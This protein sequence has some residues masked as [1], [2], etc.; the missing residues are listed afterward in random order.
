V[1]GNLWRARNAVMVLVSVVVAD[2]PAAWAQSQPAAPQ[3]PAS[4][5]PLPLPPQFPLVPPAVPVTAPAL[6]APPVVRPVVAEPKPPRVQAGT[7]SLRESA[8][9]NRRS[10]RLAIYAAGG[11]GWSQEVW[12][13]PVTSGPMV[14]VG[15]ESSL[16]GSLS[17][18][19]EGGYMHSG[20]TSRLPGVLEATTADRAWGTARI[21][22][23]W[24]IKSSQIEAGGGVV[25]GWLKTE[26]M[27]QD[28]SDRE[29]TIPRGF[30]SL[31]LAGLDA[32]AAAAFPLVG[33]LKLLLRVHLQIG[34]GPRQRSSI[35]DV[36]GTVFGGLSAGCQWNF[37]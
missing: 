9:E 14:L 7:S 16:G 10:R 2:V 6:A 33:D 8:A 31:F 11:Y 1:A 36:G 35:F 27:R 13:T 15:A 4:V 5:S 21:L 20:N 30:N 34:I 26:S 17:L 19:A 32:T 12:T 29:S 18:A 28:L 3:R 25:L 22:G 23:R 37:L 24:S